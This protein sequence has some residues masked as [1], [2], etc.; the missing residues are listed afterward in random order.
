M[1][2]FINFAYFDRYTNFSVADCLAGAIERPQMA[3]PTNQDLCVIWYKN[4]CL[5]FKNEFSWLARIPSAIN[6]HCSSHIYEN[7][8]AR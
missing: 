8:F 3:K 1:E 6:Q 5:K 2:N 7:L 4:I